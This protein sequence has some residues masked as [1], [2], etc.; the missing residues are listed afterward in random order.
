MKVLLVN[1]SP[2]KNGST[3]RAL[4]EVATTL[5]KNGIET[6]IF[7]IGNRVLSGCIAC[8]TCVKT[9]K[10]VFDDSVNKCR[11]KAL[12]ADGFIFGTP[13]H[14]AA[15]SGS[16]TAFMDRLFYSEF[17]G[18]HNK[19]FYLKPAATVVVARRAG[20]TST[21]DQLNKYFGLHEMP[22]I[23]SR[24]WNLVYGASAEQIEKD[25][26][27]MYTM[28]VLGENMA[29]FLRCKEAADKLGVKL[30]EREQPMFM[31]FIRE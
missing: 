20:T 8:K 7:R 11:E 19:A 10:C 31:N 4:E 17:C 29:Y 30:P 16:M 22:I 25:T 13:V 15:A 26:E 3:N 28:R 14:Y 9:G 18:N 1:G 21:Y 27:G 2:H 23:S 12:E 24:Y 6:E 5:N